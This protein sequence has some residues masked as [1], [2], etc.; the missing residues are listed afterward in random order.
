MK[1]ML[2]LLRDMRED[3]DMS[4]REVAKML[5]VTQQQYSQY[6]NGSTELPLRHFA[7]LVEIFS[8]SADYLLGRTMLP[9]NRSF[10][11]VYVVRDCSCV[12]LVGDILTLSSQGR[13]AVVDYVALQQIKENV[14]KP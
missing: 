12:D 11:N 1:Q 9:S 14:K 2:E 4:Q 6:E 7:K 13:K 8:V 10:E 3:K 5:G